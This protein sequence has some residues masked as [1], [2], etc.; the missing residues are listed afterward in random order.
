[1]K[2]TKK[3][4]GKAKYYQPY[5]L[6]AMWE[7]VKLNQVT[8]LMRCGKQIDLDYRLIIANTNICKF[9]NLMRLVLLL[10]FM[11]VFMS[12]QA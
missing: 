6:M 8:I 11:S 4:V 9:L 2:R 7:Y 1:M 10:F 3:I 5:V 12:V